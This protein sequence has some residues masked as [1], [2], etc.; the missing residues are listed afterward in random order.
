MLKLARFVVAAGAMVLAGHGMAQ[1]ADPPPSDDQAEQGLNTILV[2]ATR[3]QQSLQDVPISVSVFDQKAIERINPASSAE[4]LENVANLA[5]N[6]GSG[7]SNANIFLRG[8][9]STGIS[10]NLQSGVGIYA[11]EVVLN[12]PV[13]NVLQVYDL[14][15]VEVL[16]GPQNT[17]YGRNTTGG[18]INFETRKP[19]IGGSANG[20]FSVTY[21]RF[22][23]VDI[24]A[25]VGLPLGERAALRVALQSQDRNPIR[26]NVITGLRDEERD[27][28]AGRAQIAWEPT[29]NIKL[30]LKAHIER[31]RSGNLVG[32]LVGTQDPNNLTQ[33]C[34][35]PF[36]LG[37]CAT[38]DGLRG[39]ANQLESEVD[40]R[41]SRN[42]VNAG[43][44]SGRVDIDFEAFTL[45]S[46][47][48]YEE[49]SQRTS[50]DADGSPVPSF[51]FFLNNRQDQFTQEV[52]ATSKS[53]QAVRWIVG[54]FYFAENLAGSQGPLVG[55]PM[56]TMVTRS[57][58]DLESR[59]Y[60]AYG[61]IS[62][63]VTDQITLRGGGRYSV[64]E[65]EGR[66]T[67]LLAAQSFLPG[68]DLQNSLL[69]GAFAPDF[70]L[71]ESTAR[72]NGIPVFSGG[73]V[74]AGPNR[75]IIVGGPADP[76]SPLNG[77]T[78]KNWGAMAGI[79][80]KP[81]EDLLL[82][83]TWSRGFK[84]GRFNPAP[85]NIA[86]GLGDEVVRP[87][88]LSSFELGFKS[89]FWGNRGRINGSAFYNDYKDQQI[90]QFISGVF[91]V[92]SVDSEIWGAELE[93]GLVPVDGLFVDA[94]AGWLDTK[95]TSPLNNPD[96]GRRL[97][98]AAD[99][100]GT[101]AIRKEWD[102][103]DGS[104]FTLGGDARYLGNRA[105][106]LANTFPNGEP[107][108]VVNARASYE[109][110]SSRQYTVAVWGKNIFN[111]LVF[112]DNAQGVALLGDPVTYGLTLS[113]DF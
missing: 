18:A 40:M 55:T 79:D 22:D 5:L 47:T 65:I 37:A 80:Y 66:L 9:G 59:S 94:S 6:P 100:S 57:F 43:G 69:N 62:W 17:L 13:V 67:G 105:F 81:N 3:R 32:K 84:A 68:I 85:A 90:N 30:N 7:S 21:G 27:T 49:N 70:A 34:A 28:F 98:L 31:I 78:F 113:A 112:I 26:R 50:F 4:L 38:P 95:V 101:L 83:G 89:Q 56:G 77:T 64:D 53:D 82:Y 72:A 12:S 42:F 91:S 99:F 60:S 48:A 45:T 1:E 110:G 10:F 24:N 33:T 93:V 96:V 39:T 54:G 14:D 88:T 19:D 51:H 76:A 87:E 103:A 61:E 44:V 46:I 73:N 106:N 15:R 75:L 11:D 104:R 63:D 41:N 86:N 92:T 36:R 97:P 71:L 109:F 108:T 8:V 111:E 58:A 2:T 25:A 52:R 16:R 74:G 29:D 23:Q 102:F 20:A 35:T 107:Y